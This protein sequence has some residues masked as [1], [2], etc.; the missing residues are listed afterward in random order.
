[1]M[2]HTSFHKHLRVLFFVIALWGYF[3]ESFAS[4]IPSDRASFNQ[5]WECIDQS[6]EEFD[7]SDFLFLQGESRILIRSAFENNRKDDLGFWVVPFCLSGRDF[8]ILY[9]RLKV[10]GIAD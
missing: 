4:S 6:E 5:C 9:H 2:R 10:F 1:M 3:I 8:C 7:D